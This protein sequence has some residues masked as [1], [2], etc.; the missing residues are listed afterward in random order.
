MIMSL[1]KA[2]AGGIW[3]CWTHPP[4][5]PGFRVNVILQLFLLR[6]KLHCSKCLVNFQEERNC[7]KRY[8]EGLKVYQNPLTP[9][10]TFDSVN[11]L[12]LQVIAFIKRKKLL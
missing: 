9:L 11:L 2:T 5:P 6:L 4:F 1:D 3:S 12:Y 7:T 10:Y 8:E